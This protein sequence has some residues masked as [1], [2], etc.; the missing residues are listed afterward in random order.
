M[1]KSL[2]GNRYAKKTVESSDDLDEIKLETILPQSIVEEE[3]EDNEDIEI[4]PKEKQRQVLRM[5]QL[6]AAHYE[7]HNGE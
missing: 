1:T 6:A 5:K 3:N 2:D 4:I 7:K